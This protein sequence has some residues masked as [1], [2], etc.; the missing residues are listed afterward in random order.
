MNYPAIPES[1]MNYIKKLEAVARASEMIWYA[2]MIQVSDARDIERAERLIR[3]LEA[4]SQ[5][6]PCIC[7][8]RENAK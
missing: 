1:W 4:L 8:K 3:A 2:G 7:E 5:K 6:D